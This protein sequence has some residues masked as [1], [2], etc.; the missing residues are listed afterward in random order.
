[1][2]KK[3]FVKIPEQANEILRSP[4][5]FLSDLVFVNTIMMKIL[6][7]TIN[8][9]STKLK[10]VVATTK[11]RSQV[12]SGFSFSFFHSTLQAGKTPQR[13]FLISTVKVQTFFN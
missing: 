10:T 7:P 9:L 2:L 4:C 11:F 5:G 3:K 1:M 12:T 8:K 13:L 6:A